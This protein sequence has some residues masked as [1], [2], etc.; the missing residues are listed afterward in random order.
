MTIQRIFTGYLV[1]L[2]LLCG[3]V[4][5][6]LL[7]QDHRLWILV[8]AIAVPASLASMC[9][10]LRALRVPGQM[11]NLGLR[12]L[13]DGDLTHRFR[14]TGLSDI[15]EFIGLHSEMVT[16]LR[17]ER[18]RLEEQ[19]I[20]VRKAMNASPSGIIITDHGGRICD[21]SPAA[22]RLLDISPEEITG[23]VLSELTSPLIR[24]L[25]AVPKG[26][27]RLLGR[28]CRRRLRFTHSELDEGGSPRSFFVIDDLTHELWAT[29]RFAYESLIR[30]LSHEINNTVGATNSILHSALVYGDQLSSEEREDINT[31]LHVAIRSTDNLNLFMRKYAD[32]VRVPP[33]VLRPVDLGQIL[34][35][36]VR[37]ME[38]ECARRG[39]DLRLVLEDYIE[40]I[41]M[42]A[43]Q[44][45]QVFV[46]VVQNAVEA[47]D[48]DGHIEIHAGVSNGRFFAA[49]ED[50]GPGLSPEAQANLFSPFFTT[51]SHGQGVGLT[52]A[53]QVLTL[54]GFDFDLESPPD[55]PTRFFIDFNTRD[56]I[57]ETSP[58]RVY[59]LQAM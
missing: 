36:V 46:S 38:P 28:H 5:G 24:Q 8:L 30:T 18:T 12:W 47:I 22:V 56:S 32:V 44:M 1:L 35:R 4:V 10:M 40:P 48:Y 14:R 54:H 59:S 7:W 52:L 25:S 42:D 57:S 15:D 43:V 58:E 17:Q 51:K 31:A 49:V 3:G 20:L 53:H 2:H 55:G 26:E 50:S 23:K 13:R 39:I 41:A 34:S 19:D 11:V 6:L 27:S 45:E 16:R 33:P 29:E 9:L 37:L 21:V